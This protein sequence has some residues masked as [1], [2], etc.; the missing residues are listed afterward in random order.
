MLS[1]HSPEKKSPSTCLP[2]TCHHYVWHPVFN[3][4]LTCIKQRL[5]CCATL[6]KSMWVFPFVFSRKPLKDQWLHWL[7]SVLYAINLCLPTFSNFVQCIKKNGFDYNPCNV[8]AFKIRVE[9]RIV[10]ISWKA[11]RKQYN[12]KKKNKDIFT[13]AFTLFPAKKYSNFFVLAVKLKNI[14]LT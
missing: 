8:C 11:T 6:C 5:W 10:G 7:Q 3:S 9:S 2:H 4:V 1:D 14:A 13:W 12:L